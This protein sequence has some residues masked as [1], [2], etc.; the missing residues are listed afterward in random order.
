MSWHQ[1]VVQ[2]D[3]LCRGDFLLTVII[4]Q[5]NNL[6][7][8][9]L[10]ILLAWVWFKA[11]KVNNNFRHAADKDS[12]YFYVTTVQFEAPDLLQMGPLSSLSFL[13]HNINFF[14]PL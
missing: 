5:S 7:H 2:P 14:F 12:N 9:S 8:P 6:L 3:N 13:K 10:R 4:L 1:T 11:T